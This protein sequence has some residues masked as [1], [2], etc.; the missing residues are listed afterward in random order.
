MQSYQVRFANADDLPGILAIHN[1][2]ARVACASFERGFLLKPT[3]T[4]D[5]EGA[6]AK[7]TQFFVAVDGAEKLA[8]FVRITQPRIYGG[9]LAHINWVDPQFAQLVQQENHRYIQILAVDRGCM[10]QGVA[11]LLYESIYSQ[12]PGVFLSAFIVWQ[13]IQNHRSLRFHLA[14]GFKEIG[15]LRTAQF[16]DLKDYEA[17]VVGKGVGQ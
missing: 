10:G 17:I 4:E 16:L 11:R 2:N 5:L 15:R 8:G 9:L 14:Q 7:D 13:P 1:Q 3:T 6:I 12:F